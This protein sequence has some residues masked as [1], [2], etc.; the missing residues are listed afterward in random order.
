MLPH[1]LRKHYGG[2]HN[3]SLFMIYRLL[4]IMMFMGIYYLRNYFLA[5]SKERAII[6]IRVLNLVSRV[7]AAGNRFSKASE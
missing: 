2:N 4:H 6:F 5:S 7:H 1:P 3:L